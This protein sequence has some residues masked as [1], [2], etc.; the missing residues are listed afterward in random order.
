MHDQTSPRGIAAAH[1]MGNM[2]GGISPGVI[3]ILVLIASMVRL[4]D[5][6][7]GTGTD[8]GA[9]LAYPGAR[10]CIMHDR[11]SPLIMPSAEVGVIGHHP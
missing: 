3:D 8:P 11:T 10:S 9:D 4:H 5:H 1:Y 2:H 6:W 7:A